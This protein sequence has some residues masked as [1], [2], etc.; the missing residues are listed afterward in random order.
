MATL[1]GDGELK[2]DLLTQEGRL[3]LR[4]ID[5]DDVT[6]RKAP[7]APLAEAF[8]CQD[9]VALSRIHANDRPN[10]TTTLHGPG[11]CGYSI[12]GSLAKRT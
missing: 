1:V 10:S 6:T 9:K 8:T 4:G 5:G 3:A 7:V 2:V 11:G 12:P